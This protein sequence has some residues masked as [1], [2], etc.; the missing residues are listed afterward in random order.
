M[1]LLEVS[2][3]DG[4]WAGFL[5]ELWDSRS[6]TPQ[7]PFDICFCLFLNILPLTSRGGLTS[8]LWLLWEKNRLIQQ[9]LKQKG[10][11]GL[12]H[13]FLLLTWERLLRA[14]SAL[15]SA[16]L[17]GKWCQQTSFT[18]FSAQT[19]GFLLEQRTEL[20]PWEGWAST[21]SLLDMSVCPGQHASWFP[22]ARTERRCGLFIGS[23]FFCSLYWVWCLCLLPNALMGKLP[24]GFF[25]HIVLIPITPTEI[26]LFVDWCLISCL[27]GNKRRDVLC[28]HDADVT[29]LT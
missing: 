2:S 5:L 25:W 18:I 17:R 3:N 8:V 16:S 11:Q 13:Y 7:V 29:P 9:H 26:L 4:S 14:S 15:S 10:N 24:P 28:C 12:T 6:P 23:C 27:A 1:N 22:P 21:K 20:L 19:C